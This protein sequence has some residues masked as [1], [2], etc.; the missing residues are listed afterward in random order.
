MKYGV[1]V[2]AASAGGVVAVGNLLSGLP[3]TFQVP[4]LIVQ[5]RLPFRAYWKTFFATTLRC[6]L[7]KSWEAIP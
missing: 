4:I 2:I 6:P 5:H 7:W 3:V 1:V